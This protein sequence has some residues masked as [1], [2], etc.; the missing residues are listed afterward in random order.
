MEA[1]TL[2]ELAS[3]FETIQKDLNLMIFSVIHQYQLIKLRIMM[4]EQ[5]QEKRVARRHSCGW[6]LLSSQALFQNSLHKLDFKMIPSPAQYRED[7][8]CK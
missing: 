6:I 3:S 1:V 2:S 7:T 4:V 8:L 5:Q